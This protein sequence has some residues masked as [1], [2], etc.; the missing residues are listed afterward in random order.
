MDFLRLARIKAVQWHSE[1][2]H[3]YDEYLPYEYHLRM[4]VSVAKKFTFIFRSN[5]MGVFIISACWLHD[6]IED[7]RITYNDL[8]DLGLPIPVCNI[9]YAV[10]NEKGKNRAERANE[11][12]YDGIRN[13]EGAVFVKLCDRIAN[14]EY[15]KMTGGRM[16]EKYRKEN[17]DF[18]KELYSEELKPMFTYLDSILH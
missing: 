12:Y 5:E 6:V 18:T 9:V 13:T 1:T 15:S 3:K 2:N 17:A 14:A 11:K 8:K 10:S 7:C 4:V 16:L